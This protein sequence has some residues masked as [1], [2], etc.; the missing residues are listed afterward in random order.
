VY[1]ELK[2]PTA[3]LA[4]E[5]FLASTTSQKGKAASPASDV[6]ML[7]CC[8][9]ELATGCTRTPYDWLTGFSLTAFRAHDTSRMIGP[10]QVRGAVSWSL[11][12]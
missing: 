8:F 5:A 7:G 2:A 9:L 11:S 1:T 3:W 12:T 10:I 6:F 4:P